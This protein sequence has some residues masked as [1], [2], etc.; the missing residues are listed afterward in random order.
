MILGKE[1]RRN[2]S[3][4]Y[5]DYAEPMSADEMAAN[6]EPFNPRVPAAFAAGQRIQADMLL[7]MAMLESEESFAFLTRKATS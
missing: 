3:Y 5:D 2:M 7:A 1:A 4:H 6:R